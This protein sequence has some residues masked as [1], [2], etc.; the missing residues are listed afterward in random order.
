MRTI[1]HAP[2]NRGCLYQGRLC[3]RRHW[4]L[5]AGAAEVGSSKTWPMTQNT[6]SS[7]IHPSPP[8][9]EEHWRENESMLSDRQC[10]TPRMRSM[11]WSRLKF[12][13]Q[14]QTPLYTQASSFRIFLQ[15][16]RVRQFAP[17]FSLSLVSWLR[18]IAS[19]TD[20]RVVSD[21]SFISP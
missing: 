15:A 12:T 11:P 16:C 21:L 13:S 18:A 9:W 19:Y 10:C 2:S 4:A 1:L 5:R 3:P 6:P 14:Q 20:I 7:G 8:P 17:A